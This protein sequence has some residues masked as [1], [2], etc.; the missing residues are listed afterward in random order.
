MLKHKVWQA[1]CPSDDDVFSVAVNHP[2]LKA[3]KVMPQATS[4][5][6]SFWSEDCDFSPEVKQAFTIRLPK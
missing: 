5:Q 3:L 6:I 1:W 2:N 4:I